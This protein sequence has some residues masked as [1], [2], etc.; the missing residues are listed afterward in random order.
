MMNTKTTLVVK[1]WGCVALLGI[2][3]C[4]IA[5]FILELA[6]HP[7]WNTVSAAVMLA[8]LVCTAILAMTWAISDAKR[9]YDN[10]VKAGY[11]TLTAD[12]RLVTGIAIDCPWRWLVILHIQLHP[13][14]IDL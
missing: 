6:F 2:T 7:S 4:E 13:M 8:Y 5:A 1:G 9:A 10:A 3:D 11:V 14:L 12:S